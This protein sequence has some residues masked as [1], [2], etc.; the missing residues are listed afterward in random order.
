MYNIFCVTFAVTDDSIWK[1]TSP[2]SSSPFAHLNPELVRSRFCSQQT[3]SAQHK[4]NEATNSVT[5]QQHTVLPLLLSV[6]V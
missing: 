4:V 3:S 2:W 5:N 6:V 1:C